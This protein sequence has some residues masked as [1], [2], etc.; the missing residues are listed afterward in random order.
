M[1][2]K[3]LGRAKKELGKAINEKLGGFKSD[4]AGT[5]TGKS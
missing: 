2:M 5:G 1:A 3:V 4:S